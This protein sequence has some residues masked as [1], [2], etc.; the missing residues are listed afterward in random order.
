MAAFSDIFEVQ[1]QARDGGG[2]AFRNTLHF[3]RNPT[4]GAVD[5]TFLAALAGDANTTTLR[6]KYLAILTASQRLDG[7]L[8][9]ATR[10]PLFPDD[11]RDE[12][13]FVSNALGTRTD[14][15]NKAPIELGC[16]VKLSGDLAGRR[17]RG[18]NWLPPIMDR[19]QI[20]GESR[21]AGGYETAI[22]AYLAELVKTTY[23]SGGS[24]YGGNWND[25]DMVVYSRKARA[26]DET[27]YARVATIQSTNKLRWLRSR[28]PVGQ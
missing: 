14:P 27:Y 22:N 6:T 23:P 8:F 12:F 11:E 5:A 16:I 13:Y 10:D 26:E 25:V 9:R 28:N 7:I 19:D 20:V 18:R 17:Y 2:Q 4:A 1:F 21:S 24:H 15:T 3:R